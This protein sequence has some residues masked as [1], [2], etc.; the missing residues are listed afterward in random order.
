MKRTS[1]GLLAVLAVLAAAGGFVL[2]HML[3]A[4]GRTTFTPSLLLPVLL[5]L[6]AGASLGVAWPVR[7]SVRNGIRIDPFRATRAV[8]LARASSLVGAIMAGFGAGLLAFLLSRPIDP[9]VGSTVAMVA[10][11]G[12]AIVLAVVALIAEQFCTLPKD[13][14]DSEPR[15]R[16]GDPGTA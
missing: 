15:D 2:D 9:P 5:L 1:L 3:T 6:I 16:A 12:S 11:I 14:D 7:A 10:L 4:M 13:P 8:T